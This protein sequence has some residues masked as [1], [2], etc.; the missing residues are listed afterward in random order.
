[1][2]FPARL[3]HYVFVAPALSGRGI[4]YRFGKLFCRLSG[5]LMSGF[6]AKIFGK[7]SISEQEFA[8]EIIATSMYCAQ[9]YID[10]C[11]SSEQ[12]EK[13]LGKHVNEF[14]FFFLHYINRLAYSIGGKSAQESIYDKTLEQVVNNLVRKFGPE[15]RSE[16]IE[17][18]CDGI[19][20]SEKVYEKCK[21]FVAE[22]DEG[23]ANTLLWEAA[24]RVAQSEDIAEIMAAAELIS[25]GMQTLN[26]NNKIKL[27]F[28]RS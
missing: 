6:M 13:D 26:L 23:M 15:H 7:K 2:A 27:M 25:A 4:S 18:Y 3:L 21:K 5:D 8:D 12:S 28:K 11:P 14:I 16:L 24:K 10:N 20:E 22:G 19:I 9:T 1:L 17:H